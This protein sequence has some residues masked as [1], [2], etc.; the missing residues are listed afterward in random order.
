M[1]RHNHND[2]ILIVRIWH[3]SIFDVQSCRGTDCDTDLC[4]VV[5]NVREGLA[6]SQQEAQQFDMGRFNFKKLS[7][8][9]VKK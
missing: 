5:A 6:V 4:L 2:H 7:E 9:E 8:V 1:G 3:S